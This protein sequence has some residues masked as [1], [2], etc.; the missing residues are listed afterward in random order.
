MSILR[1]WYNGNDRVIAESAAEAEQLV[2]KQ[3]HGSD[4]YELDPFEALPDDHHISICV[5]ADGQLS[6]DSSRVLR[7]TAREWAERE[8]KGY[9]CSNDY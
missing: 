7:L 6:D 4:K 8:G 9:L 1:I 3:L 5:D 2:C